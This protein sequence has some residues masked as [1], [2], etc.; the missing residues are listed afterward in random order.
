M[1]FRRLSTLVITLFSLLAPLLMPLAPAA[2]AASAPSIYFGSS[3]VSAAEGNNFSVALRLNTNGAAIDTVNVI[4]SFPESQ[5]SLV[6]LDKGG[7]V[8][9]TFLP[10][11]PS[12]DGGKLTFSAA[13]LASRRAGNGLLIATLSFAA[14]ADSGSATLGLDGSQAANDGAAIDA[15]TPSTQVSFRKASPDESNPAT[16]GIDAVRVTDVS[17]NGGVVRWKTAVAATS[18]V[19]YGADRNYGLTAGSSGMS[20]DHAVDLGHAF[21]AKTAVH[22][23]VTSV[24]SQ[25]DRQSSADQ[26]FT[27]LGYTVRVQIVDKR[28]QPQ[29]GV[30]VTIGGSKA[31]QTDTEGYATVRNIAAGNQR[32]SIDGKSQS[33]TVKALATSGPA[34][35]QQFKLVAASGAPV[36]IYVGI[37]IVLLLLA[38]LGTVLYRLP[39]KDKPTP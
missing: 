12:T 4:V 15:T 7:S 28:S 2:H 33:I 22:F 30:S 31:V 3:T 19:D 5:L 23:R 38:L 6:G 13:S 9:D 21:A 29:S 34:T 14:K 25:G 20:T 37:G 35:T 10:A 1:S 32:V 26:I 24:D 17:L 36:G 18:S 8:F 11:A 39:G 27:T 16:I